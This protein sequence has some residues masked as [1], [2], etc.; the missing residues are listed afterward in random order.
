MK[1]AARGLRR[2]PAI[3]N[4]EHVSVALLDPFRRV[5]MRRTGLASSAGGGTSLIPEYGVY[6]TMYGAYRTKK[7]AKL[8]MRYVKIRT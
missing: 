8:T 6:L 7:G 3:C 1:T 2:Q 5:L 4:C